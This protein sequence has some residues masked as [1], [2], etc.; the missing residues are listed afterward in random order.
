M[1]SGSKST[2]SAH[3]LWWSYLALLFLL[4]HLP[5]SFLLF[6]SHHEQ[7]EPSQLGIKP[8]LPSHWKHTVST[9]KSDHERSPGFFFLILSMGLR[10]D[11]K[12]GR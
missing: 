6:W 10:S 5:I 8:V 9:H 1:T 2:A 3:H 12:S 7:A 4:S 11:S